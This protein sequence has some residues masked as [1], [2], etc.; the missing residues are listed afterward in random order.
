VVAFGSDESVEW[1]MQS[2]ESVTQWFLVREMG[3]MTSLEV[4]GV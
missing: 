4:G 1:G 2:P 3:L